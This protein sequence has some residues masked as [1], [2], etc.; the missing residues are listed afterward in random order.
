MNLT[1]F[2]LLL[3]LPIVAANRLILPDTC[4]FDG[5]TDGTVS[6]P[7]VEY[8][9]TTPF[10]IKNQQTIINGGTSRHELQAAPRAR[11]TIVTDGT[12][13]ISNFKLTNGKGRCQNKNAGKNPTSETTPHF[14][15]LLFLSSIDINFSRTN[16]LHLLSI[17][18]Y[19]LIQSRLLWWI[20][21]RIYC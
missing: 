17:P 14:C 18:F 5:A 20:D 16:Q 4:S 10:L 7:V 2:L 6:V 19:F 21:C 15:L 1:A 12:F 11:H 8:A 13:K 3:L 9:L